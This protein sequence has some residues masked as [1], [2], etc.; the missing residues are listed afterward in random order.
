MVWSQLGAIANVTLTVAY[1]A[2]ARSVLWPL[3]RTGQLGRN[4][5]GLATGMIFFSCGV[6][7]AIHAEHTFR[8]VVTEGWAHTGLDWHLTVWDG[9]TAVIAVVYWRE[10]QKTG[11]P[12]AAG[13]L[14]EDLQ[15]RQHE[16]ELE[17]EQA[18]LRAELA[19]GRELMA[20]Q[21]FAQAFESAPIGMA[22]VDTDGRLVHVNAAF[23]DALRRPAAEL[24]GAVLVDLVIDEADRAAL[25]AANDQA[26]GDAVEVRL[27]LPDG[28]TAWA[29][30]A[31]TP[32]PSDGTRSLV[33]LDDVTVRRL[34]QERLNHLA[35]HDPLTGL[36]NR[37]LFHDRTTTALRQAA[38]TGRHTGCLFID[39]DHFKVVND[40]LGHLAGDEVLKVLAERL[41]AVLRPGDT[42]ARMGG[43]EFCLLLQELED[44]E[45]ATRIAERVLRAVEGYVEVDGVQI[46]TGA[47]IG[48]AV[49]GPQ[50]QAS[51]HTLVRDADTAL[52]RAKGTLRGTHAVFDET[53]RADAQHRMR[54]EAD[55]RVALRRG[56]LRV[57]YQPQWSLRER[58]VV[59]VEALVRW[60]HPT[61][62]LLQPVDFIDIAVETG[63][64]TD[65]GQIVLEQALADLSAWRILHDDL[66]LAVNLSSRQL[67]RPGFVAD[68]AQALATAGVPPAALC[69]ELTESDLTILGRSALT[70]LQDLRDLGLR[71]AV[72]DVG[73][74]QSS[75]SHLVELPVDA[76]KID[77]TFVDRV[78]V[79]GAERAVVEALLSLARTIGLHVVAEGPETQE[80]LDVLRDLGADVV[81]GYA[82]SEPLPA[83]DVTALLAAAAAPARADAFPTLA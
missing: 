58:R 63:L 47:S 69:L 20:R 48:V 3:A 22:L 76:I 78:Q 45:E 59:G 43:D 15:R 5:L 79:P 62:G 34:A 38:R 71:L 55:L 66:E 52:Y 73:T 12:E 27:H 31:V 23:A 7:H 33:Q 53:I 37:V 57:L 26:T 11:P 16:L 1:L 60:D 74:G 50:D 35:L 64:V 42:V 9:L 49:A 6:G 80:Q 61:L 17:A 36:P 39:L 83:T 41:L 30:I 51:S 70:T 29:R 40:S 21:S 46:T 2:I 14:F 13:N 82:I 81:Q 10:R 68:V 4:H 75:L 77:R 28:D 32:L 54:I 25:R 56:E 44:P 24:A 72:D 67:G 18:L 19:V 8:I 65:L